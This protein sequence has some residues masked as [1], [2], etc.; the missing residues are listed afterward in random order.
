MIDTRLCSECGY[1]LTLVETGRTSDRALGPVE[2][3]CI[4]AECP[5]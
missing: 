5:G 3:V 1:P 2:S 4:D